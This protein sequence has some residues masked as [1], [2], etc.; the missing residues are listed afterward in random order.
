[1]GVHDA[2]RVAAEFGEQ[3]EVGERRYWGIIRKEKMP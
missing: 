2:L 3:G 1:V